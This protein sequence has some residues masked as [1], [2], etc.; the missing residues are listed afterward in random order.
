MIAQGTVVS[1]QEDGLW[2]VRRAY[3]H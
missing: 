1:V 2:K 3:G